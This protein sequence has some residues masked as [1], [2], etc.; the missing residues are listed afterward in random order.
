MPFL[1]KQE[2]HGTRNWQGFPFFSLKHRYEKKTETKNKTKPKYNHHH[3]TRFV[4]IEQVVSCQGRWPGFY[5]A[6]ANRKYCPNPGGPRYPV[7]C[8]HAATCLLP[9]QRHKEEA[10]VSIRSSFPH[11]ASRASRDQVPQWRFPLFTCPGS[12]P[13]SFVLLP[14]SHT[15]LKTE[16]FN[17]NS[18][19]IKKKRAFR[20]LLL[21]V[22]SQS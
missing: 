7:K 15:F 5:K 1:Q 11:L 6:T 21:W 9:P 16:S 14:K 18:K 10:G 22:H 19:E 13:L 20:P 3:P 4:S 2:C 8:P 17:I 12:P